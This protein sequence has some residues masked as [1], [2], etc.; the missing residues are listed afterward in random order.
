MNTGLIWV[1]LLLLL[2]IA[3]VLWL[4]IPLTQKIIVSTARMSVQ[5]LLVGFYLQYVFAW[6]NP[7][8]NLAWLL[9]MA[10]VANVSILHACRLCLRCFW[11]ELGLSLLV[12]TAIPLVVFIL[13]LQQDGALLDARS[14]IPVGG[15]ILG[16]CMRAN[17]IG[18]KSFYHGLR[19]DQKRFTLE[20]SRGASLWE[21]CRLYLRS[22]CENALSPT[23]ATMATLGL[24]SLPGMMTGVLLGGADPLTAIGYQI[25]IMLSIFSGTTLT[26]ILAILLTIR[27]SFTPAGTLRADLFRG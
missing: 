13:S 14:L 17:I 12:G 27:S 4:K 16:N 6:N 25:A 24:V 21:A 9:V 8:I 10:G 20:L 7:L 26:V 18:I 23:L 15:M 5:L 2:P 11:K 22:S 1:Y 19:T 3:A